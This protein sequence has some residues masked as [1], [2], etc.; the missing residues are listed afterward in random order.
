MLQ[1][2]IP[3]YN[4]EKYIEKCI[5]SVLMQNN[6]NWRVHFIN[7]ASTDNSLEVAKEVLNSIPSDKYTITSHKKR[8]RALFG[9]HNTIKTKCDSEN[10]IVILDGDDWLFK[11]DVITFVLNQFLDPDLWIFWTQH[12]EY[13]SGI[14]GTSKPLRPEADIRKEMWG[15]SQL[16]SFRTKL[17]NYIKEDDLLNEDGEIYEWVYDQAIMIPMLEMAG[18]KHRKFIND[19]FYV[20]NRENPLSVNRV[21]FISQEQKQFRQDQQDTAKHIR[22]RKPYCKLEE[23]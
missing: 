2:V 18:S 17:Y 21:T 19:I 6:D 1:F 20:Y 16:R 9:I 10:V 14:I 7:D 15:A 23:M 13:P 4:A 22:D 3:V 12:I 8:K 5:N 11:S